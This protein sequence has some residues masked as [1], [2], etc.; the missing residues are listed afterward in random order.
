MLVEPSW[1]LVCHYLFVL[2]V[3]GRPDP[4]L[5][6]WCTS[7]FVASVAHFLSAVLQHFLPLQG[8]EWFHPS[9]FALLFDLL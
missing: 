9:P 2:R 1:F 7:V 6:W 5:G 4:V 3:L 8:G